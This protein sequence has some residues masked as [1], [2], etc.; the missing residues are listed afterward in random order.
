MSVL[1]YL[2]GRVAGLQVSGTGPNGADLSWRGGTPTLFLNEMTSDASMIQS[3]PMSDVAMIKVF[4]PPFFG[5]PGG[6]AGGAIAVYTKKGSSA[7]SSGK[8]F[9]FY[10][11]SFYYTQVK[12]FYSPDYS[13]GA[14]AN[15]NDYRT[16]L[17][18]NPFLLF[19]KTTR[20]VLL[21]FTTMTIAR[22]TV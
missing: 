15:K 3:L 17:Y 13:T 9:R 16:T 21:P 6:G 11:N 2:R 22:D 18:W 4:R 20:R 14:D 10:I 1:D 7:N 19:D 8:R 12:E 5:A